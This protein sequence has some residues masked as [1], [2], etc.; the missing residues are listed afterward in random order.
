MQGVPEEARTRGVYPED[1][2]RERF[3]KVEKLARR[4]AIVP[5]SD[6]RLPIYLLSYIQSMFILTPDNPISKEELNNE[7]VD[8]SKFDTYD[9]LNRAKY[10]SSDKPNH[11]F[12]NV[13]IKFILCVFADTGWNVEISCKLSS[14]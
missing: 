7:P 13:V 12:V 8:F 3:I 11:S 4:L 6:A 5:A 10:A 14:T 1:A 2:L 9:I